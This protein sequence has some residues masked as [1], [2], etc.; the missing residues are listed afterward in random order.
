[1]TYIIKTQFKMKISVCC[2]VPAQ[3]EDYEI[4]PSCLEYSCFVFD[5]PDDDQIYNNFCHEGGIKYERN[6]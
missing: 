5:E 1:M 6:T 4:C 3:N 2:G